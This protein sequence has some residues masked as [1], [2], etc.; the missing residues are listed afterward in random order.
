[1]INTLVNQDLV[2]TTSDVAVVAS[3]EGVDTIL[4]AVLAYNS[5]SGALVVTLTLGSVF[6]VIS[7]AAG[8]TVNL[9][10]GYQ[11]PVKA[12]TSLLAKAATGALV[13]I[14]AIG[15]KASEGNI[16]TR[17]VIGS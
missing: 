4:D 7:V 1:M 10:D 13:T 5:H 2:L 14:K 3:A 12:G 9:T 11:L 6:R 17:A 16:G 8:A 15:R